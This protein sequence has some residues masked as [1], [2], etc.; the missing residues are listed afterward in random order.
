MPAQLPCYTKDCLLTNILG[1]QSKRHL[2]RVD[3]L[4]AIHQTFT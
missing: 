2:E 1:Y 4:H 3:L